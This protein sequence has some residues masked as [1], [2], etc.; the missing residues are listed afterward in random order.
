MILVEKNEGRKINYSL[1]GT[2]ITFGGML[3]VDLEKYE[4]EDTYTIYICSDRE[5]GLFNSLCPDLAYAADIVIPAR[6]YRARQKSVYQGNMPVVQRDPV[7]FDIDACTL[8]LWAV[9][10]A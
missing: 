3:S 8:I 1:E 2:K 7:P 4:R 6:R 9:D 5:G 10:E